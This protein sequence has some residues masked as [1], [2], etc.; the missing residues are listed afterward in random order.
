MSA[1]IVRTINTSSEY[2]FLVIMPGVFTRLVG[3][4]LEQWLQLLSIVFL[5]NIIFN[6]LSGI[7]ADRLGPRTVVAVGGGLGAAISVPLFYYVPLSMPHNFPIAAAMGVLYGA[8]LAAFVPLSGLMPQV[9]PKEKAAALS[10]LGLG[11]GASTWV[12]PAIV[13]WF[14]AWHGV[15]GVIWIFSGLYVVSALL[16]VLITVSPE[17]KAYIRQTERAES[18]LE[19]EAAMHA[20]GNQ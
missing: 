19:K 11:A 1:G 7:L 18:Q 2:A 20:V 9:C 12:G 6:L 5:S 8:S 17:A 3:F 15:E 13:T 4:S 14:E 10:I 16:T